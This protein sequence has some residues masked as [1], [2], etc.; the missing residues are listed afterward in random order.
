MRPATIA[1]LTP[2]DKWDGEF[3]KVSGSPDKLKG[4]IAS[5]R[6]EAQL[7]K[8]SVLRREVDVVLGDCLV[9]YINNINGNRLI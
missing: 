6:L 5:S 1:P 2:Y 9:T 8:G 4:H 3:S 7:L